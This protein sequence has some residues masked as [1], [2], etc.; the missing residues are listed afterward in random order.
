M[1]AWKKTLFV[2]TLAQFSAGLGFSFIVP[3]LP[4]YVKDLGS[5][6]SLSI[7]TLCGLVFSVQALTMAIS[8]PFWGAAA[9]RFGRKMMVMRT[10]LG[11]A[12]IFIFMAHAGSAE[13]LV[14]LRAVQGAITGVMAAA[15]ALVASVTPKER[16]GYSFG[17]LQIG[18]WG[19]HAIGPV[20]GGIIA[21]LF[22]YRYAF[23][24]T[25]GLLAAASVGVWLISV[26]PFVRKKDSAEQGQAPAAFWL[27]W[28]R[29]V[30]T[31][32]IL[33]ILSCRFLLSAGRWISRPYL[34][35]FVLMLL[36]NSPSIATY[37]GV[38]MG[39]KALS[40][41]LSSVILGRYGDRWGHGRVALF[42]AVITCLAYFFQSMAD[43]FTTLLL[44]ALVLGT[45]LGGLITSLGALLVLKADTTDIG[46][47]FGVDNSATA[48]GRMLGPMLGTVCVLFF[49]L[50][51]AFVLSSLLFCLVAVMSFIAKP[52]R[53]PDST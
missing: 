22:G 33:N 34:P 26:D 28:K 10:L 7:E 15:S 20:V 49:S 42:S 6:S 3:F 17:V 48:F 45:G 2:I 19:G 47:V 43:D 46:S 36:P 51:A 21:D 39:A 14:L 40:S 41:T 53:A 12:V 9:D 37:T 13:E 8:A 18:S 25:A 1:P 30:L 38:L 31:P 24:L 11:G 44:L 4:L 16:L 29:I 32:G 52:P 5:S 50:R 27:D 23:Y 35:L